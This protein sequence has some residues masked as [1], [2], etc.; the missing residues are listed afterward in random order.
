[1]NPQL[2]D[3]TAKLIE[4]LRR[5]LEEYGEMLAVL[6][7][8]QE[9]VMARA[10]EEVMHTVGATS[11][12]MKRIQ[13]A[14]EQR[15]ELQKEVARLAG[16][17]DELEFAN[18]TPLLPPAYRL[19]VVS[20]VRENNELLVR[21]QQRARQ[22]YLLLGRALHLMQQFIEVLM[23]A[24]GPPTYNGDGALRPAGRRAAGIYEAVG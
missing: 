23:P 8:Q 13:S 3:L 22:N 19:A 12:Q 6:D 7:R 18:L 14:R 15:L 11:E 21:V 24:A 17:P 1:M 4:C 9:S 10:A 20:L 2:T 5:E 16:S